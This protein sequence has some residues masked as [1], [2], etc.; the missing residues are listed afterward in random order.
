MD[1]N[2]GF[3]DIYGNKRR[4]I[5]ILITFFLLP[6]LLTFFIRKVLE[7]KNAELLECLKEILQVF[8]GLDVVIAPVKVTYFMG[9]LMKYRR[10]YFS[11]K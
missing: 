10:E 4:C 8:P 9:L 3:N 6:R 5:G 2:G 11:L 7:G 1:W